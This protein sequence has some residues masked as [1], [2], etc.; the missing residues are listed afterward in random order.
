MGGVERTM[1]W[2]LLGVWLASQ[3]WRQGLEPEMGNRAHRKLVPDIR[4]DAGETDEAT[5][6]WKMAKPASGVRGWR[7][8]WS[9]HPP[10]PE[11]AQHDPESRCEDTE[12]REGERRG[13]WKVG[14]L[15]GR[16]QAVLHQGTRPLPRS[17]TPHHG[18]SQ[19]ESRGQDGRI[20]G[21][22]GPFCQQPGP[23]GSWHG[24]EGGN[25]LRM[26][27][28]HCPRGRPNG[29]SPK[30]VGGSDSARRR[31]KGQ[32]QA[33]D[34]AGPWPADRRR[35]SRDDTATTGQACQKCHPAG[36]FAG[37]QIRSSP[38]GGGDT[39]IRG[40]TDSRRP[41]PPD[42]TE[43]SRTLGCN[44]DWQAEE[45]APGAETQYQAPGQGAVPAESGP[46]Q[47]LREAGREQSSGYRSG[48]C[49]RDQG[50]GGRKYGD[51]ES[52]E[53]PSRGRLAICQLSLPAWVHMLCCFGTAQVMTSQDNTSIWHT[54]PFRPSPVTANLVF[55]Y[56]CSF[57]GMSAKNHECAENYVEIQFY[58]KDLYNSYVF[59]DS[60]DP[61]W[62]RLRDP[63]SPQQW[64]FSLLGGFFGESAQRHHDSTLCTWRCH[65]PFWA[66]HHS[67]DSSPTRNSEE[68]KDE[69]WN[70]TDEDV[71]VSW[72]NG[73]GYSILDFIEVWRRLLWY[74]RWVLLGI[75]AS[76]YNAT[77]AALNGI[78]LLC[79]M[80]CV[81]RAATAKESPNHIKGVRRRSSPHFSILLAFASLRAGMAAPVDDPGHD[82]DGQQWRHP[83]SIEIWRSGLDTLEEQ[84]QQALQRAINERPLE[85]V[86]RVAPEPAYTEPLPDEPPG[87]FIDER[88]TT[89]ISVWVA[90]PFFV[91]EALDLAV[92]FPLTAVRLEDIV[93]WALRTLPEN[94][95]DLVPAVPQLDDD[96]ASY[97]LCPRWLERLEKYCMV[98]DCQGIGG[99]AFAIYYEGPVTKRNI[100]A[101]VPAADISNLEVF[102]FG[103]FNP[104]GETESQPPRMG[105]LI[106]ILTRGSVCEWAT[107]DLGPRLVNTTMWRPTTDM[108]HPVSGYHVVYQ[109]ADD[110]VICPGYVPDR[111]GHE[112]RGARELEIDGPCWALIPGEPP[113]HLSHG[114]QIV[115][116]PIAIL[117][118]ADFARDDVTIIF[119][120][121]RQ[122]SFFPQWMARRGDPILDPG[123]YLEGIQFPAIDGWEIVVVGGEPIEGNNN[124]RVRDGE[125]MVFFMQ[126][127]EPTDGDASMDSPDSGEDPAEDSDSSDSGHT[128]DSGAFSDIES[129]PPDDG[130]PRGPPPPQPMDRS[131]SPRRMAADRVVTITQDDD[132]IALADCLPP[133]SFDLTRTELP[134]PHTAEQLWT[135]M[136]PWPLEWMTYNLQ[137]IAV[138]KAIKEEVTEAAKVAKSMPPWNG[139]QMQFHLFTDGSASKDRSGYSVIV[140]LQI[141]ATLALIGMIGE[142]IVG[143][144][145]SQWPTTH[146]WAL[147][148]E[149]A[150]LSVAL[151]WALQMKTVLPTVWCTVHYDCLSAGN[152]ASGLWNPADSLGER[153]RNLGLLAQNFDGLHIEYEHVKGH[154]GNVWNELADSVAKHHASGGKGSPS[155]PGDTLR[156]FLNT[157]LGWVGFGF[158]MASN[159]SMQIQDGAVVWGE[160]DFRPFMLQESQLVPTVASTENNRQGQSAGLKI[161]ACSI[162]IQ[163]LAGHR[164]YIEEQLDHLGITLAFLQETKC[165]E[166]QCQSKLYYRLETEACRHFGVAIWF[167]QKLGAW[168]VDGSPVQV[169]EEDVEI[170]HKDPRL[171]V[172]VVRRGQH[173]FA[174]IAGHCPHSGHP[175]DRDAFIHL[176]GGYLCRLKRTHFLLCGIDLNGRIPT[177]Y[178]T[179][180]GD[181]Q[182]G[183]ADTTGRL[184][185]EALATAGIWVPAT[186]ESLH[187]G[188][189]CTYSH[190]SG[191][192]SR[193]DYLC[194]GG[195]LRVHAAHSEVRMDFDNGSPNEDHRLSVLTLEG[196]LGDGGDR[197]RLWRPT[198]DR[199]KMAT[200]EGRRIIRE[201]CGSFAHPDWAT[202]P[203]DHCQQVQ[204][205]LVDCLQR[206]FATDPSRARASYIPDEVWQ[207]RGAKNAL[208]NRTRPRRQRQRRLRDSA[209]Y[210][211]WGREESDLPGDIKKQCLLYDLVASAVKVATSRI[212]RLIADAKDK[213]LHGIALEGKQGAADIMQRARKAG[214][215]GRA[216]R[217][218]G[219]P[220]PRLLDPVSGQQAASAADRD[221]IWLRFFG[222]Q[223]QGEVISTKQLIS[224]AGQWSYP[225][226]GEWQWR[227]LPST[228]DIERVFRRVPKGKAAGLDAI[229]SDLLSNEPAAMAQLMQPLYMK[230]LL[231]A[232]Q[233]LQWRGGVLF[234]AYKNSGPTWDTGNHRSLYISSFLG[235]SLHRLMRTKVQKEVQTFLHP[236]HCG[237]KRHTPILFPSLF[238]AEHLRRCRRLGK[239]AAIIFVDC[240]AAYY[241]LIR[242]L[243]VGDIRLDRTIE[244]LFVR[245]GLDSE[246]I[247]DLRQLVTSGGMLRE[248]EVPEVICSTVRDFHLHTWAVTR[249]ADGQ[250]VCTSRAG[251][252]P[253]ASWADTLFAFIYAKIL[254]KVHELLE[255]EGLNHQLPWDEHSG[256]FATEWGDEPQA[257]WDTTWADDSAWALEGD[258]ADQLLTRAK[259]ASSIIVS[260]FRSHG[261]AP[262]LKRDKTS[263]ILRLVGRGA[264]GVRR[265]HFMN[266]KPELYLEDLQEAIPIVKQYRHLGAIID[267]E[268]K[269][270]AE[271]RHRTALANAAYDSARDLLLQNRDLRMQTRAELFQSAVVSTY[272]NL[273]LWV[274][275]GVE[276]TKMS[277][278]FSRIVR[279]LLCKQIDGPTLF[280]VPLPLIH[281]ATGCWP[282]EYYARR[283]R[284]SAVISLAQAAPPVLWATIQNAKEWAQQLREDLHWLVTGEADQWPQVSAAGW[285]HWCHLLQQSP[286]RVRRRV[287]KRNQ[288]DFVAYQKEEATS[289]CLWT[290]YR[291]VVQPGGHEQVKACRCFICEKGFKNRAGLGA[292]F[293]KSHGRWATYRQ[294]V[295]GTYCRACS[296][297]FWSTARL[298]DHLRSSSHCARQLQQKGMVTSEVPAGYGSR[299][300]R[301]QEVDQYTPAPPLHG[302]VQKPNEAQ[303]VWSVW[304]K[305]FYADVCQ[306]LQDSDCETVEMTILQLKQSLRGHPLFEDEIRDVLTIVAAEAVELQQD[307]DIRHWSEPQFA[308]VSEALANMLDYV[309][310]AT[311]GTATHCEETMSRVFFGSI[312]KDF[313]WDVVIPQCPKDYVTQSRPLYTLTEGWEAVWPKYRGDLLDTAVVK[314]PMLLLPEV[315]RQAWTAFLNKECPRLQAPATFWR[316]GLSRPFRAFREV[317]AP[318]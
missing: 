310:V 190:P 309:E 218:I 41:V 50:L 301:Q 57:F 270:G 184:F 272:F 1:G 203:D 171:L 287:R 104:L 188:E 228:I 81:C 204:D 44:A 264:N 274:T 69:K 207:L 280:R 11:A 96:F 75:G 208:R 17:P 84:L 112:A 170:I 156:A 247:D 269:L 152:G 237:S 14:K 285:P 108:P 110:Q 157:D 33:P 179:V 304:K 165:H 181:L 251:S 302:N 52:T 169:R 76:A 261:L 95:E 7:P 30:Y 246:D 107:S 46:F 72:N 68:R 212:K 316:H 54:G 111:G 294:C 231:T 297:E 315:L 253:G 254:Y 306:R 45:Q 77:N 106:R 8:H 56:D 86:S 15:P 136:A 35:T 22:P 252:R 62:A 116:A 103:Q 299:K 101:Q 205:H 159:G 162:N 118:E 74:K 234:E 283:S 4:D 185:A 158:R 105:G 286:D 134:F 219:R 123:S 12:E 317:C 140:L 266:G 258:S 241:R 109:G 82:G 265:K 167:H 89:H 120:D 145:L 268:M 16:P 139:E 144:A 131:R 291:T 187:Q 289:V 91:A 248:A 275:T 160:Q 63:E 229:P 195:R 194:V 282:L 303:Q 133:R 232:H 26:G 245:F 60:H 94:L 129:A 313:D 176:L 67:D 61:G 284:I 277:S 311:K 168:S 9:P 40:W 47:P 227:L 100:L 210:K 295:V 318:S 98:L 281:W 191:I 13:N 39:V 193:I 186:F 153:L 174:F 221:N 18:G 273:P 244:A 292:H 182:C 3:G 259:R 192:E 314:D 53:I 312:V 271:R 279:R 21:P 135:M 142:Q 154:A 48:G 217:P 164:K 32:G 70:V 147:D 236:L 293:Y 224:E 64:C 29:E 235:K 99:S 230:A 255:G 125:V 78:A 222:D 24:A 178:G 66:R 238:V 102:L 59:Q 199:A 2:F 166:G 97:I 83:S 127:V 150:A 141:G 49:R 300:R 183:E 38:N 223:E 80:K 124:L 242:E 113:E 55:T 226:P 243:A 177:D 6:R 132:R 65:D 85:R 23:E 189:T 137:E 93:R 213:F 260:L 276:W 36:L 92:N 143:N 220:L 79:L 148:A 216:K 19:G 240:K 31:G 250:Q 198:F 197:G 209:F 267:P 200:E 307:P 163:G 233:P 211:W 214:I 126:E 180:S 20:V 10:C 262:N 215:G 43:T 88:P 161:R 25:Q 278:A 42:I 87:Q 155:P 290:L 173:K 172:V 149:Q 34:D 28:A 5:L 196:E 225:S 130:R 249:F 119:L 151:L 51:W 58:G 138:D 117:P 256:P 73:P 206:H 308:I 122:I 114:G 121:L 90:A 115:L 27:Q 37:Q 175:T 288:D 201:A 263:I 146:A 239:S 305:N 71:G 128:L 296:T 202:H 298:E 257:A